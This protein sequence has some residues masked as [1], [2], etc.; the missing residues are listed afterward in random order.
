MR[1]SLQVTD[2]TVSTSCP[3]LLQNP[4]RRL[5]KFK[6]FMRNSLQVTDETVSTS[7]PLLSQNPPR[8][9]D[10]FKNSMR[11]SLQVTDE[12]VLLVLF[13]QWSSFSLN[14]C[15]LF[16]LYFQLK[17]PPRRFDKFRNYMRNSLKVTD[18]DVSTSSPLLRVTFTVIII[19]TPQ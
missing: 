8:R 5:D 2:E 15:W 4:P 17:N 11:N 1:T 3:L 7:S 10:K 9:L 6:N 14:R 16:L 19:L 18:D 13:L 12:T